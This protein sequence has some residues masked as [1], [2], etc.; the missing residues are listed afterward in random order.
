MLVVVSMVIT[1]YWHPSDRAH[2]SKE[3][4]SIIPLGG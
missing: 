2:L 1:I 3:V 4:I